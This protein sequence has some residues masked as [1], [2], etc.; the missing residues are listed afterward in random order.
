MNKW[1]QRS[2][3]IL[4]GKL[5]SHLSWPLILRIF[6]SQA[7]WNSFQNISIPQGVLPF[8]PK[9]NRLRVFVSESEQVMNQMSFLCHTKQ[10]G[11][12]ITLQAVFRHLLHNERLQASC[13]LLKI[14]SFIKMWFTPINRTSGSRVFGFGIWKQGSWFWQFKKYCKS[15]TS[16]SVQQLLGEGPIRHC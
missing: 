12:C 6:K 1:I 7:S 9:N 5:L 15:I 14:Y 16:S 2:L 8:L 4:N 10:H 11:C 3:L 13:F